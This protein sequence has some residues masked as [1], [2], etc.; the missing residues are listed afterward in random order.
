ML[1][2]WLPVDAA[3]SFELSEYEDKP[4]AHFC[5]PSEETVGRGKGLCQSPVFR[6]RRKSAPGSPSLLGH[7]VSLSVNG[8]GNV[9]GPEQP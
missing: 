9:S 4:P 3:V 8:V 6:R 5:V 1:P 7:S 2:A